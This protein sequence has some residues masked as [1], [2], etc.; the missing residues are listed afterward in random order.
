MKSVVLDA[1]RPI[2]SAVGLLVVLLAVLAA[3]VSAPLAAAGGPGA[4]TDVSGPV[5]SLLVQPRVVRDPA[6]LL[7]VAWIAQN[8]SKEDLKQRPI[9][10]DGVAGAQ[11]VLATGWDTLNNPAIV[12]D[13]AA[14]GQ[15]LMVFSGGIQNGDPGDTHDGLNWWAS[16]DGG[17]SWALQ[18]G[19]VSG[20]GGTAY[21]SDTS[22]VVTP[23]AV[24][25]TWFSSAGVFVHRGLEN[26]SDQNVNDVGDFGYDSAL[27]YDATA[28]ALYVVAAYNA[29]GKQGLW[30]R[31][32]DQATGAGVG[33]SFQLPQS[34]SPYEG[35]QEFSMKQIPV[36]VTGLTGQG[37]LVIAY[38]TGYPTST[39]M[40]V[41]RLSGGTATTATL[42]TGGSEKQAAAVAA[43]PGG[44]VWVVWTEAASDLHRVYACRSNVGATAWGAVVSV[45][46]PTGSSS[47]WE[48]AASAQS[49]RL[50]VLAQ[51]TAGADNVI[52][53]TQLLAGL[54][55]T[56]T[57]AT[58]KARVAFKATVTV[59]DAGVPVSGATVTIAGKSAT[60]GAT[61]VATLSVRAAKPGKLA[62]AV[63][64]SGYSAAAAAITVTR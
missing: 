16:G 49:D 12:Y 63:Q 37:G 26:G 44:R 32:I 10:A 59:K 61:G 54:S 30:A 33:A 36:P 3:L 55:V 1:T 19:V 47:L 41:W 50:D 58:A 64:K 28:N 48:L 43:D 11:Q 14:A 40:R 57:P 18:P 2:R 27:G 25:Q 24:F 31:Q 51:F 53:H 42:A 7:Q 13:A 22:A 35:S 52:Y 29:T 6:G 34:T 9:A 60:T 39:T 62:V 46:G 38:P 56:V 15:Q 23:S 20:P 17:A 4:W 21:V 45:P 5:G 8:G